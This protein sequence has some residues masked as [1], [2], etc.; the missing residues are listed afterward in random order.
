VKKKWFQQK[1]IKKKQY[2]FYL[3]VIK[4]IHYEIPT[5]EK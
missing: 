1:D 5:G 2:D 4:L 3:S